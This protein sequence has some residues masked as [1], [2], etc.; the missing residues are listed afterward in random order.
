MVTKI[1]FDI[2]I[3]AAKGLSISTA[4]YLLS[5]YFK[6]P[7][8]SKE[9]L[10]KCC[11]KGFVVY[12]NYNE[13]NPDKIELT[14]SGIKLVEELILDSEFKPN[15]QGNISWCNDCKKQYAKDVYH[16]DHKHFM[17]AHKI[18]GKKVHVKFDSTYNLL[19]FIRKCLDNGE[20]TIEIKRI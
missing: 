20:T 3:C 4:L 18:N 2:N 9:E 7:I 13:G 17:L 8:H 15:S 16:K 14:E 10:N 6:K 12:Y 1:C 19:S 11:R 5:V